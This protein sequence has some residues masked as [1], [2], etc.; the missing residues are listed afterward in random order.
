MA[1]INIGGRLQSVLAVIS[2]ATK[3][4]STLHTL[5]NQAAHSVSVILDEGV[6]LSSN[7]RL[8]M[9]FDSQCPLAKILFTAYISSRQVQSHIST[10]EKQFL[11]RFEDLQSIDSI[12]AIIRN[13][14]DMPNVT[15][16]I[17]VDKTEIS[18]IE[19]LFDHLKSRDLV[20]CIQST[21]FQQRFKQYRLRLKLFEKSLKMIEHVHLGVIPESQI[22][23]YLDSLSFSPCQWYPIANRMKK[24][25]DA[26][27]SLT[28]YSN[29]SIP[30]SLA[31]LSVFF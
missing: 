8:I 10:V 5:K 31:D 12:D 19:H 18:L 9:L 1:L 4:S 2:K 17:D 16:A 14:L 3:V 21:S 24:Q 25:L 6:C 29:A 11:F 23:T 15:I 20:V 28:L 27:Q 13:T 22:S 30:R 26:A 7:E